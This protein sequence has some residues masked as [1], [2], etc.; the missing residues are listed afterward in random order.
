MACALLAI[1]LS[2]QL[3]HCWRIVVK[4]RRA[5]HPRRRRDDGADAAADGPDSKSVGQQCGGIEDVGEGGCGGGGEGANGQLLA[6]SQGGAGLSEDGQP[7]NGDC[8][9]CVDQVSPEKGADGVAGCCAEVTSH[10]LGSASSGSSS[11]NLASTTGL[12]AW[13]PKGPGA[14]EGGAS[15]RE[16]G[17]EEDE[18]WDGYGRADD[19]DRGQRWWSAGGVP[20]QPSHEDGGSDDDDDARE[21]LLPVSRA[22]GEAARA[23]EQGGDA[24]GSG[25]RE[26][27]PADSG[28]IR[29]AGDLAASSSGGGNRGRFGCACCALSANAKSWVRVFAVGSVAGT[30]SG[31]M[32]G[33]TGMNGP[34][35]MIMYRTLDTPKAVVRGNNAF[36]NLLQFRLVPYWL[37]GLIRAEDLQLHLVACACGVVGV[38]LGDR[39]SQMMGQRVF[40][41][42]LGGL[43]VLCCVLMFASGLGLTD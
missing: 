43:M 30:L 6:C 25:V 37:M 23:D 24:D 42:V 32:E 1:I 3:T 10:P 41:R 13:V 8:V 2:E 27:G 21:P 40:Q 34:P 29:G 31:I 7:V 18:G 38:V 9:V 35:V 17:E 39:L 16:G 22:N 36:L 19:A 20:H 26:Q 28:D 33:L 5:V 15:G 4:K 11:S 14:E 12:A